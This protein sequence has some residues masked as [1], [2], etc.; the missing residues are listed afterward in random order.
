MTPGSSLAL[1]VLGILACGAVG[2]FA[3]FAI[4]HA[5]GW[6][7]TGAALVAV[8]VGMAVA[9]RRGCSARCC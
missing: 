3:G 1:S 4:V 7:G 5:F 9:P 2:A 8:V 6:S